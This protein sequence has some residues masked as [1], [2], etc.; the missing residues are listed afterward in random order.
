MKSLAIVGMLFLSMGLFAQSAN[1]EGPVKKKDKVCV[2]KCDK[3]QEC[4]KM[5]LAPMQKVDARKTSVRTKNEKVVGKH[6]HLTP[7][8]APVQKR[9]IV[10]PLKRKNVKVKATM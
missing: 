8:K 5:K 9:S 10:A 7:K 2:K 1:D 4:R 3:A 6:Q